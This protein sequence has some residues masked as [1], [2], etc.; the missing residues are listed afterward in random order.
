MA[1]PTL[2]TDEENEA[3]FWHQQGMPNAGVAGMLGAASQEAPQGPSSFNPSS[4]ASGTYQDLGSR[5]AG[6]NAY[7]QAHGLDPWSGDAQNAYTNDELRGKQDAGNEHAVGTALFNAND[8]GV[9]A[10]N[11]VRGFERPGAGV[12]GGESARAQAHARSVMGALDQR[13]GPSQGAGL[14]APLTTDP[15]GLAAA[16]GQANQSAQP[17]GA[18]GKWDHAQVPAT[19]GAPSPNPLADAL[20]HANHTY[21]QEQVT[22]AATSGA[23]MPKPQTD[24]DAWGHALFTA[25]PDGLARGLTAAMGFPADV[26]NWLG[27]FYASHPKAALM[28]GA[29]MGGVEPLGTFDNFPAYDPNAKGVHIPAGASDIRSLVKTVTGGSV[30]LNNPEYQNAGE[31]V[32]SHAAEFVGA[33]ASPGG[34]GADISAGKSLLS[35]LWHHVLAPASISGGLDA[36]EYLADKSGIANNVSEPVGIAARAALTGALAHGLGTLGRASTTYAEETPRNA[37]QGAV[38]AGAGP[39]DA[40]A[41]K[42]AALNNLNQY[43]EPIP[44][45][46]TPAALRTGDTALQQFTNNVLTNDQRYHNDFVKPGGLADKNINAL[47]AQRPSGNAD[48]AVDAL[49]N[50]QSRRQSMIDLRVQQARDLAQAAEDRVTNEAVGGTLPQGAGIRQQAGY[51]KGQAFI[52]ELGAA[53]DDAFAHADQS[54]QDAKDLGFTNAQ[55]SQDVL[56]SLYDNLENAMGENLRLNQGHD[57][58]WAQVNDLYR[59]GNP[60]GMFD[61]LGNRLPETIWSGPTLNGDRLF[62]EGTTLDQLKG[63]DS[64]LGNAIRQEQDAISAPGARGNPLLLKNLTAVRDHVWSAIEDGAADESGNL[65]YALRNA[66]DAT[67]QAYSTFGHG[68]VGKLLGSRDGAQNAPEAL[69]QYLGNTQNAIQAA[70]MFR[71]AMEQRTGAAAARANVAQEQ[72]TGQAIGAAP[73]QQFTNAMTDYFRQQYLN[74]RADLGPAASGKWLTAHQGMFQELGETVPEVKDLNDQLNAW[75]NTS[76]VMMPKVEGAAQEAKVT[77]NRNAAQLF[78]NGNGPQRLDS[79]FKSQNPG[80]SMGSLISDTQAH[81]SGGAFTGLQDMMFDRIFKEAQVD[82]PRRP[83]QMYYSGAAAQKFLAKPGVGAAM[84]ALS[85]ADPGWAAG[86]NRVFDAMA[87]EDRMRSGSGINLSDVPGMKKNAFSMTRSLISKAASTI[88]AR[89]LG[90]ALAG[91]G[92]GNIQAYGQAASLGREVVGN[93]IGPRITAAVNKVDPVLAVQ[94]A[95]REAV[96]D[97]EKLR[98]LLAPTAGPSGA[99]WAGHIEPWLRASGV[100]I[101]QGW[102]NPQPPQQ[103]QDNE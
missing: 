70:G 10:D 23:P 95:L 16:L 87:V 69:R 19:V 84:D 49:Q 94:S 90:P 24:A 4:G 58:P 28:S 61:K 96:H 18:S 51:Q 89:T 2:T 85:K 13:Y 34:V 78:L 92:E 62:G 46:T 38:E 50:T 32:L 81:G 102:L 99:K 35:M 93:V 86:V 8:P 88:G 21:A 39:Q 37:V 75:H 53:R 47:E 73:R 22:Q 31:E 33:G 12:E 103:G 14:E 63:V 17:A 57:F 26:T 1:D 71:G 82:D 44:G 65:S 52:S 25:V 42:S 74:T 9:A 76:D 72:M 60:R 54:W 83:G 91:G 29:A 5:A 3:D 59:G 41:A 7:A 15:G 11:M 45:Y 97:P 36:G 6:E 55:P 79:V 80:A 100:E 48:N 64:R 20:Q 27:D 101:P 67:K 30:D 40:A 98:G 43:Q 68:I 56:S 77:L 66:M